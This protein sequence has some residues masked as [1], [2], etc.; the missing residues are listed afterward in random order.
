MLKLAG[1]ITDIKMQNLAFILRYTHSSPLNSNLTE[2]TIA[3]TEERKRNRGRNKKERGRLSEDSEINQ[4]NSSLQN[5]V[6][7]K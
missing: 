3:L 6:A 5:K 1:E 7:D 4:S 2:H